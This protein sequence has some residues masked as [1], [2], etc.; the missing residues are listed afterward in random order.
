MDCTNTSRR[1]ALRHDIMEWYLV[2]TNEQPARNNTNIM[3]THK[4]LPNNAQKTYTHT[5]DILCCSLILMLY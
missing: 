5:G 1:A 3:R 2:M 4:W